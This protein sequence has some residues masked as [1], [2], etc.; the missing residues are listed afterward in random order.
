MKTRMMKRIFSFACLAIGAIGWLQAQPPLDL[1]RSAEQSK[2]QTL[3]RQ[4]A[5]SSAFYVKLKADAKK[6]MP[7]RKAGTLVQAG[8]LPMQA[9]RQA[10]GTGQIKK[11]IHVGISSASQ[12]QGIFRIDCANDS[13]GAA[14]MQALQADPAVEYVEK[15]PVRRISAQAGSLSDSDWTIPDD[16][17]YQPDC[18]SPYSIRWHLDLI[19]AE[20]AW[21]IVQ[22]NPDVRVAVVDNAVWGEHEDLQIDSSLQYNAATGES[23]SR[24][25]LSYDNT[26]LYEDSD[27]LNTF[28][29]WSHGTHCA[30]LVGALTNNAVGVASVAGGISLMGVSSSEPEDPFVMP[31]TMEGIAWAVENGADV[32]SM[33]FGSLDSSEAEHEIIKAAAAQGVILV[34]SAGNNGW[35][36]DFYPAAYPEVISVGSCDAD[37]GRSDFSNFGDWVDIWSPGGYNESNISVFS[38][39]YCYNLAMAY[40]IPSLSGVYYDMMNGTSMAAPL[41]SSVV[42]LMLS[43]DSTLTKD[44][45]LSILQASSQLSPDGSISPATGI[46]DAAAALARIARYGKPFHPRWLQSVSAWREA[47]S[48]YPNIAWTL[49]GAEA[50]S[51][52]FLRLYRNR[53]VVKDSIPLDAEPFFTDSTAPRG[54]TLYYALCEVVAGKESYREGCVFA[55]PALYSIT[56]DVW[57]EGTGT[58]NGAGYYEA[59]TWAYIEAF[60]NSG[61]LFDSWEKEGGGSYRL[62]SMRVL[63]DEDATY[64]AVFKEDASVESMEQDKG[65][66]LMPNPA[67]GWFSLSLSCDAKMEEIRLYDMQSRLVRVYTGQQEACALD[68]IP[69]GLY[70]VEV[71]LAGQ[72]SQT[73]KLIVE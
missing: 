73:M 48:P 44:E 60:P 1:V 21:S 8:E 61:W 67:K 28:A 6:G 24:P 2:T 56:L 32:I 36:V 57:P 68:G 27:S 33:S 63:M 10:A 71:R 17:Y 25:P 43:Y 31:Y 13:I 11:I 12:T 42:A 64:T 7:T 55:N 15:V 70:F 20:E 39:T 14:L 38:T 45:I 5:G 19:H 30:G 66:L 23:S 3:S 46:V 40:A 35:I 47:D 72:A 52:V 54:D 51:S 9:L 37:K 4:R 65:L 59:G 69:S 34:G 58:A 50:D 29:M 22:G 49:G 16:P 26:R 18:V 53:V 41:I 62:Q